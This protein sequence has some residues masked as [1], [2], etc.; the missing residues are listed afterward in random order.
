MAPTWQT[1][2]LLIL[3]G[4]IVTVTSQSKVS[5]NSNKYTDTKLDDMWKKYKKA[6][7]KD[8][9]ANEEM[10]RLVCNHVYVQVYEVNCV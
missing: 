8:Y 2:L 6:H 3:V 9:D 7:N 5:H 1:V 10:Y 4:I